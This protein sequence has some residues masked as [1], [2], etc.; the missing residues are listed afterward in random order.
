MNP[1]DGAELRPIKTPPGGDE[2]KDVVVGGLADDDRPDKLLELYALKPR[3]LLGAVRGLRDDDAMW[4]VVLGQPT[5]RRCVVGIAH[6][7][8]DLRIGIPHK[9]RISA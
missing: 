9:R 3:A 2:D 1:N 7:S 6:G 5:S 8:S 4:D